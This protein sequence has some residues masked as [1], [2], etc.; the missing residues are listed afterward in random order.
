MV[1]REEEDNFESTWINREENEADRSRENKTEAVN[2]S[3]QIRTQ[4]TTQDDLKNDEEDLRLVRTNKDQEVDVQYDLEV[5][6]ASYARTLK[7][8]LNN[9]SSDSSEIRSIKPRYVRRQNSCSQESIRST[10]VSTR[11][12]RKCA[13]KIRDMGDF[14]VLPI[15]K[16]EPKQDLTSKMK[17]YN[18][19]RIA[20]KDGTHT[21]A[22][23]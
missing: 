16:R 21:F 12:R 17:Q 6:T 13:G 8:K 7:S 22:I 5:N 1:N 15:R 2:K 3:T 4:Q 9:C 10:T 14:V 23:L 11:P 19:Q 20:N 18:E